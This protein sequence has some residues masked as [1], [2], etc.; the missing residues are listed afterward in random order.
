MMTWHAEARPP[1]SD[2]NVLPPRGPAKRRG[3][4]RVA[5]TFVAVAAVTFVV[6]MVPLK[7]RC[8]ADG[9][10]PGLL[11]TLRHTNVPLLIAL[12][13][14]Y[15][16][17][18]LAWAA[19]WRALLGLAEL[20]LSLLDTWRI[21]LEA[22]AGGIL[23]PGGIAGDALRV[24]HVH[25]R[26]P[27][28]VLPKV[29]ASLFADRV[30]GLVTLASLAA[31]AGL[32]FPGTKLDTALILVGIPVA[33]A[34]GWV[35]VHR[36]GVARSRFLAG[37]KVGA[38]FLRPILEY[39]ASERGPRAMGKGLLLSLVVSGVQLLVVRGLI[40]VLG[41]TPGHEA[42][43][44]VGTTF[45]MIIAALP[46]APASWGTAE[47]AYVFFLG[48]AGIPASASAAVC[49]LYR[50]FWYASGVLGAASALARSRG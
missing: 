43:V 39:A 15:I 13:G 14:L 7:D 26:A 1:E 22:Q 33:S 21:T 19:R 12:F 31:A 17:G 16:L 37:S 46:V 32:A 2:S 25:A 23:L 5:T 42:L 49:V 50:V 30:I 27:E 47:A 9:C 24:A 44:Y 3:L 29:L 6:W 8:T 11:T 36:P 4:R 48:Q 10:E 28:I 40:S 34:V 41:V 38:R 20:K 35:L 18:T 45:C